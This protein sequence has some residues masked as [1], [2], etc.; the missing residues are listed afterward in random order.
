[1]LF[2]VSFLQ[3]CACLNFVEKFEEILE[4][5]NSS[6]F[7]RMAD[8]IRFR[9][10]F[11]KNRSANEK[12]LVNC[13]NNFVRKT[14]NFMEFIECF[15]GCRIFDHSA[16]KIFD[17]L[18][19]YK[20]KYYFS[21]STSNLK[22]IDTLVNS[23]LYQNNNPMQEIVPRLIF[24]FSSQRFRALF[25]AANNV[26][27]Q[28][29]AKLIYHVFTEKVISG[30][31]VQELYCQTILDMCFNPQIL[32]NFI[33]NY[34]G[35]DIFMNLAAQLFTF[36]LRPFEAWG[37]M[38]QDDCTFYLFECFNSSDYKYS[39]KTFTYEPEGIEF[40]KRIPPIIIIQ[41]SS[42]DLPFLKTTFFLKVRTKLYRLVSAYSEKGVS[43][44][45]RGCH[46]TKKIIWTRYCDGKEE[47]VDP[48]NR[49]ETYFDNLMFEYCSED[50]IFL[51][52]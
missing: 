24:I 37:K 34:P 46:K 50:E 45:V 4:R 19:I 7:L 39:N 28:N 52:K 31:Q 23:P 13:Y 42:E 17:Y 44:L 9:S 33:T 38:F 1:M 12:Y 10:K 8:K 51:E 27:G 20:P 25:T 35:T 14:K 3:I 29:L 36:D 18:N 30:C 21:K 16:H 40:H 32:G 48:S 5:R 43:Y 2:F 11:S 15:I 26:S 22:L 49:E 41:R 47:I 6:F